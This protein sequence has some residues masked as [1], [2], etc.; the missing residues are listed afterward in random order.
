VKQVVM[1]VAPRLALDFFA[2]TVLADD[3]QHVPVVGQLS[4]QNAHDHVLTLNVLFRKYA[5]QREQGE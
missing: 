5:S 3:L 2:A 1:E 4:Q